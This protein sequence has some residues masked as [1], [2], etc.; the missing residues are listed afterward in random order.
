MAEI[1]ADR[2]DKLAVLLEMHREM[3]ATALWQESSRERTASIIVAANTALLGFAAASGFAV[4]SLP[5]IAFAAVLA[6]CGQEF[7]VRYYFL[8]ERDYTRARLI[9]R[10]IDTMFAGR[11]A[12]LAAILEEARGEELKKEI[13]KSRLSRRLKPLLDAGAAVHYVWFVVHWIYFW[14]A[15]AWAIL[16]VGLIVTGYELDKSDAPDLP[17]IDFYFSGE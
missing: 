6:I 12:T 8:Q 4:H 17:S 3:R 7:A 2:S 16:A 9:R 15:F 10:E 11:G 13:E 14:I 1:D 5:L